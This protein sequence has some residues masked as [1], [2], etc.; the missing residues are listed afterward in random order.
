LELLAKGGGLSKE[1]PN[2]GGERNRK[3]DT[4]KMKAVKQLD[5]T[6]ACKK[7]K[8]PSAGTSH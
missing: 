6:P 4:Y 5:G 7:S 1:Q 8:R 2:L 3:N